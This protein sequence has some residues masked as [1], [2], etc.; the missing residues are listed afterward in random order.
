MTGIQG[1]QMLIDGVWVDAA[2]GAAFDSIN[3]ATGKVWARIPEATSAD[4]DQAVRA[5]DRAL[6]EGPWGSL[7]PTERG[8]CLRRLYIP[9]AQ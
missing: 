5:A 6:N 9:S 7:S 1:Y 4:V 3:P 8:H 2:D